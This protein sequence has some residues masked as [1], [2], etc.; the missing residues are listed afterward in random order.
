MKKILLIINTILQFFVCMIINSITFAYRN[1]GDIKFETAIYQIFS[2]LQGTNP[3]ILR[4]FFLEVILKSFLF[5]ILINFIFF[6]FFLLMKKMW[7]GDNKNTIKKIIIYGSTYVMYILAI[8]RMQNFGVFKYIY[9]LFNPTLIYE[10]E[11]VDPDKV[12][13]TFPEKKKNLV[14]IYLESM[15]TTHAFEIEGEGGLMPNLYRLA[16]DNISFSHNEG[17][18]GFTTY[19]AWTM[20]ALLSSTSGVNYKM[21]LSSNS[22]AKYEYFLPGLVSLGDIL[23]KEGY[24]NVFICGSDSTFAGR[25][26]YFTQ[27]G[28]Y[29]IFD[30]YSAVES[31]LISPDYQEFWGFEDEKLYHFAK[32]ELSELA[33]EEAPFNFTMLT[34]DTH[35]PEGYVCKLC[36]NNYPEQYQNIISCADRQ[37][38]EFIDWIQMQDWFKNTTVIIVG[39]HLISYTSTVSDSPMDKER[40]VYNCFINSDVNMQELQTKNRICNAYDLFPTTLCAMGATI[41]GDRLGLGTNLFSS[42]PTLEEKMGK[43][44]FSNKLGGYSRYYNN[45]FIRNIDN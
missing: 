24:H 43:E 9:G 7:K 28:N 18:G 38:S 30:Y 10:E 42:I 40:R 11:Y 36:K 32:S 12:K 26:L 6:V 13:I 25:K 31:E 29:E 37:I 34:V 1:F 20:G 4:I 22:P 33:K 21:P 14:F 27:H 2:P 39:D 35:R 41:E 44:E 16:Q 3:D 19:D 15:E 23:E 45:K 17:F 5:V 8:I